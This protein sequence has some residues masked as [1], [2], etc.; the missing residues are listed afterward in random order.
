VDEPDNHVAV[1]AQDSA[2]EQ[3]I[4]AFQVGGRCGKAV[5]TSTERIDMHFLQLFR[6]DA[7]I[8]NH[9]DMGQ[10]L[11]IL[12]QHPFSVDLHEVF[13]V[14]RT[15]PATKIN[16]TC[17]IARTIRVLQCHL[18]PLLCDWYDWRSTHWTK[19]RKHRLEPSLTHLGAALQDETAP[20]MRSCIPVSRWEDRVELIMQVMYTGA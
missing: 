7:R 15:W 19:A 13:G 9:G 5:L 10:V 1:I 3:T 8:S 11:S 12:Q 18:V 4:F 20:Q 16:E 6:I 2:L 17:T 14:A